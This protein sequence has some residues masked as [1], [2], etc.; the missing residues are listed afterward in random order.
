MTDEEA[1]R[2]PLPRHMTFLR[3]ANQIIKQQERAMRRR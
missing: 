2:M 1:L 3:Y